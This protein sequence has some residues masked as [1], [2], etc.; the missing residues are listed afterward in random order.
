MR[1]SPK[2]SPGRAVALSRCDTAE[3]V[4]DEL[5]RQQAQDEH[6]EQQALWWAEYQD[7]E[8]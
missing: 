7:E 6:K 5:D 3:D 8:N 2:F 4:Q 1:S